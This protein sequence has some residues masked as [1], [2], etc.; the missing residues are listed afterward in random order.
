MPTTLPIEL[1]YIIGSA[2]T[3]LSGLVWRGLLNRIRQLE[4][5]H[6]SMPFHVLEE[7]I[8]VIKRDI[9]WIKNL[10]QNHKA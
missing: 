1:F 9:E 3:L 6:R 5:K 2:A 10:F 7:D 8:A 4:D